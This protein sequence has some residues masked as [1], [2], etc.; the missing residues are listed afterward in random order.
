MICRAR[1]VSWRWLARPGTVL[2]SMT[3]ILWWAGIALRNAWSNREPRGMVVGCLAMARISVAM[4]APILLRLAGTR[5]QAW[6]GAA[7]DQVCSHLGVCA[8]SRLGPTIVR[9]A[10][11]VS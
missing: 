11:A 9:T 8:I 4:G 3:A 7:R 6:P 2:A 5:C 10:T 1:A